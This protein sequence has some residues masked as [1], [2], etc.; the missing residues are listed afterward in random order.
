MKKEKFFKYL[1]ESTW[2][3]MGNDP[4]NSY[5]DDGSGVASDD[6]RPPGNIIFGPRSVRRKYFNKLTNYS[7]IWDYDDVEDF[8]WNY[9]ENLEGQED[10]GNYSETL[11]SMK[12]LFP[13]EVWDSIWK[14]MKNVPDAEVEKMFK[15][16]LKPERDA[17][18]QLGKDKEETIKTPKELEVKESFN[19]I[20]NINKLLI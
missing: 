15:K 7:S 13:E 18:N 11:K 20:N 14:K 1:F 16:Q 5:P 3:G 19:L 10:F 8:K 12:D 4:H 2:T 9:F 6:D 17:E